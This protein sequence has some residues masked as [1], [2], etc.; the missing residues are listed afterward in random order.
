M[1]LIKINAIWCPACLIMRPRF[2]QLKT[3]FPHLEQEEFDYDFDEEKIERY[4]VGNILPVLIVLDN[5][6]EITRIIGEK[7]LEELITVV[8]G[9]EK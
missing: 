6:K 7:S 2:D 4:N 3:I 9:C 1:K 8:K 5:D